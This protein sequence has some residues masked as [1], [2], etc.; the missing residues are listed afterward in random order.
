M[1]LKTS[2]N[3]LFLILIAVALFAALS[4]AL[5]QSSRGSGKDISD[6]QVK[7][8]A[9]AIT[10]YVATLRN[11]VQRLRVTNNCDLS[12]LDWRNAENMRYNNTTVSNI[13]IA[14]PVPKAGC[15]V[16]SSYGGSVPAQLFDKYGDKVYKDHFSSSGVNAWFAA[17][18]DFRWMNRQNEGSTKNEIA[19]IFSGVDLAICRY[20]LDPQTKP[21]IPTEAFSISNIG[22]ASEPS[23]ITGAANIIDDPINLAGDYFANLTTYSGSAPYCQLGA[24]IIPQ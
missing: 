20:L 9:S 16:F 24:I 17:H 1:V 18:Y 10:Q 5:T 7:L 3:V 12:N 21:P 11:E 19:I 8:G 6:E 4:Y 14:A 22:N 13:S 23:P 2:G 15:S